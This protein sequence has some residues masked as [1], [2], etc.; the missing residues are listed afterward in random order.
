L[1]GGLATEVIGGLL[2]RARAGRLVLFNAQDASQL[3]LD[4]VLRTMVERT[5][6]GGSAA[7]SAQ[8]V[9]RAVQRAALDVM[10]DV[11]GDVQAMPEVRALVSHHLA[12]LHAT[13][14]DMSARGGSAL[15]IAHR[16]QARRDIARFLDGRDDP[17][18]RTRFPVILLP[19]P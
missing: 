14:E 16:A 12:Q 5:W 13:L 7:G 8:V 19:W 3:G 18:A 6:G 10:L 15:E 9:Q 1:A 2:D 17:K 4:E 11:A